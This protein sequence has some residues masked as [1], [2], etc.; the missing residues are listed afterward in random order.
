MIETRHRLPQMI[1]VILVWRE[2]SRHSRKSRA[3]RWAQYERDASRV[4]VVWLL[5]VQTEK[6]EQKV[7]GLFAAHLRPLFQRE[8]LEAFVW[9]VLNRDWHRQVHE[10]AMHIKAEVVYKQVRS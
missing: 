6:Y 5:A 9:N 3:L 2:Q 10:A 4:L 8:G 1:E 7:C